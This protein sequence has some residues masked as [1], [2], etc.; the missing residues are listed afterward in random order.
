VFLSGKFLFVRSGTV[1]VALYRLATKRI[2]NKKAELSQKSS[3][4][5]PYISAPENFRESLTTPTDTF[6]EIF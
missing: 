3:R 5:A 6:P 2:E 1:G 4:D